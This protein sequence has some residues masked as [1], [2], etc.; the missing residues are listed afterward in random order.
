MQFPFL[1]LFIPLFT[2]RGPT[3]ITFLLFWS[4]CFHP[5]LQMYLK[6]SLLHLYFV[7]DIFAGYGIPI[8]Q[9]DIFP[10][11]PFKMLLYYHFTCIVSSE[12]SDF[13]LICVPLSIKSFF[14]TAS[15]IVFHL[16]LV[17][18]SLW[19]ALVSSFFMYLL[20]TE[21]PE[22]VVLKF[23]TDLSFTPSSEVYPPH[24]S[25]TTTLP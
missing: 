6:M 15:L 24:L 5:S 3:G 4:M 21:L 18:S 2:F 12:K 16:S 11:S 13:T 19:C 10:L 1:V 23:S 8:S 14:F 17:F 7:K 9:V 20:F 22:S 25:H